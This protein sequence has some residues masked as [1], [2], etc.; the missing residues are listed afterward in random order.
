[1]RYIL[2]RKNSNTLNKKI[3]SLLEKEKKDK[4]D[5][6]EGAVNFKKDCEL[7][8]ERLKEKLFKIKKK[9]IVFVVMGLPQKV[10]LF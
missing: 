9:D 3:K 1:M 7:S 5:C 2:E 10:R 4:I 6:L 8:K